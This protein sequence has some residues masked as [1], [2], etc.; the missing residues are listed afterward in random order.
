VP[1]I[2]GFGCNVPAIMTPAPWKRARVQF[3][4]LMNPFMSCSA[5]LPVYVLFATVFFPHLG[6]NVVFT[7]HLIGI[8]VAILTRLVM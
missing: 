2:V 6:Q 1:L 5:R 7:L 3:T 8:L 4:I